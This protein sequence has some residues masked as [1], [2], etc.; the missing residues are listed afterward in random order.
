MDLEAPAMRNKHGDDP[1]RIG[2]WKLGRTIGAGSSGRVRIAR[3]SRT[4][5]YAAIKIVSKMALQ[6]QVSLDRLADEVEHR[7]LAIE[8]EIVVMKLIDHPNIMRLYDVWETS[9]ELFLVLEYI[10]GGEL[11]EYLCEK[12]RLPVPEALGYFQQIISAVDYCH[13]FNIAHRDLKPENILLDQDH[14]IKIADFGMAAWQVNGQDGMLYT[15][16]GSPHYAA[17]EIISGEPYNGSAAD[18]WSCGIILYALMSG[19][20]PFDDEDCSA[21]L[22]KVMDGRYVMPQ[23]IHP[24]AQDLIR[25]MLATDV[26]IR[27]TM[28]EI[29]QHPF[30]LLHKPKLYGHVTPNLDDIARPIHTASSIDPDIFANLRTLW[31]G[32]PDRDIIRSLLNEER[33]WQ[34]GIYHLLVDYRN[35]SRPGDKDLVTKSKNKKART[36]VDRLQSCAGRRKMVAELKTSDTPEIVQRLEACGATLAR[37]K[38]TRN[39]DGEGKTCLVRPST[40]GSDCHVRRS[41]TQREQQ[42][43]CTGKAGHDKENAIGGRHSDI[44]VPE[45][46]YPVTKRIQIVEPKERHLNKPSWSSG[47]KA[48]RTPSLSEGETTTST[49][50]E[51]LSPKRSWLTNVLMFRTRSRS[52]LSTQDAHTTRNECRRLLMEMGAQVVLQDP[53]GLG[54]LKCRLDEKHHGVTRTTKLKVEMRCPEQTAA[55]Y[56][57]SLMVTREKGSVDAFEDIFARLRDKWTLD[58]QCCKVAARYMIPAASFGGDIGELLC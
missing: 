30:Y 49:A 50:P 1:K 5:Q 55:G 39:V 41:R 44:L 25:K 57:V 8:R 18:I 34:K 15:S 24:L 43:E 26:R 3:H 54:I 40:A 2:L 21:L 52:L 16:C 38:V 7:Q 14:N 13:R 32:T 35:K 28:D 9:A 53:E 36:K 23:G 45:K 4:G 19:K 56:Q 27:I 31:H 20:L 58:S 37:V 46:P 29:K 17:P 6:S 22:M 47:S 51:P 48:T 11:F 12:G 42:I 10:Q 33:N